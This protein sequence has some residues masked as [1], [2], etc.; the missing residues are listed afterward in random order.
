[1]FASPRK[2]PRTGFADVSEEPLVQRNV[3]QLYTAEHATSI[4]HVLEC[5]VLYYDEQPRVVN[6]WDARVKAWG[7]VNVVTLLLADRTGP[8]HMDVWRD[9][10]DKIL[11]D[12]TNWSE[13]TESPL[14]VE[15]KKFYVRSDKSTW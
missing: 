3:A 10:A 7:R 6:V 13:G 12:L 8:I 1:M 2:R 11:Q 4:Q 14:I 5:V 15:F 9:S